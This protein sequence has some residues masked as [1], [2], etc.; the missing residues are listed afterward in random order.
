MIRYHS[1]YPWHR[2]GAYRHLMDETDEAQLKAVQAFNRELIYRN[3]SLD[4]GLPSTSPP[5]RPPLPLSL[6]GAT[7]HGK[8]FRN[9]KKI[10]GHAPD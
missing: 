8:R 10:S 4:R 9:M 7:T 2:E 5:S 6:W 3:L 1:F